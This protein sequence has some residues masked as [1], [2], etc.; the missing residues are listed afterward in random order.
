MVAFMVTFSNPRFLKASGRSSPLSNSATSTLTS[1]FSR[2]VATVLILRG[3]LKPGAHIIGG[4]KHAKVRNMT[5]PSGSIVKAAYPGMAVTVSGWKELPD[6]GDEVLQGTESDIKKAIANR[7]RKAQ[8][9]AELVD[10]E[11]I[12]A[13]RRRDREVRVAEEQGI[14]AAPSSNGPK[15]LRVVIKGD[16][17]GSVEA[18][19]GA[20]QGIGNHEALLK[21]VSTGV[22]DVS[23]S[24]VMMAKAVNGESFLC[25]Y[26]DDLLSIPSTGMVVAFSV[27]TPRP[28]EVFA[29]QNNVPIFSSAIIYRIMD[30]MKARVI[31][32]LPVIIEKK[33]TGEATVLQLF[34]VHLKGNQTKRVAGCRVVNGLVEK[35][36]RARVVRNSITLHEGLFRLY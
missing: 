10:V 16:V 6:A 26:I 7:L 11:A 33:V 12:N 1:T 17:S 9:E 28:V 24:D 18:V 34:D 36:K 35:A 15:E 29:T 30:E 5:D 19:T 2:P 32:L 21:V 3:C 20:I 25:I 23:E 13:Q 8:V 4:I 22:G 31:S 27:N 14:E